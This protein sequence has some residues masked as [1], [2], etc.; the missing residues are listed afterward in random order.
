MGIGHALTENF[1]VDDGIPFTDRLA[2]YRMPNITQSPVITSFCFVKV[3]TPIPVLMV[4]F[5]LQRHR[6]AIQFPVL[7]FFWFA[8]C[9]PLF[10]P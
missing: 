2:R 6:R 3:F 10:P 9:Q 4:C 8:A 1:I 5:F 7:I